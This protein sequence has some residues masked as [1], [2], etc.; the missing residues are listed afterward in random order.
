MDTTQLCFL[1]VDGQS[2]LEKEI[3]ETRDLKDK[4]IDYKALH[5][6]E[7][8]REVEG[9]DIENKKTPPRKLDYFE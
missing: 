7:E 8:T 5:R 2:Q 9:F 1:R 4:R 3:R 6:N